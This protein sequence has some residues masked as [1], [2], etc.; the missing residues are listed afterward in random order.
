MQTTLNI[1]EEDRKT[2]VEAFG[3]ESGRWFKCPNGHVYVVT[4]C[5][6]ATEE[7]I[8]NECG[9]RVGGTNHYVG[10]GNNL[11]TEMD[12]AEAPMFPTA[13]DRPVQQ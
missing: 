7:S 10:D 6:G 13:L 12:G 11:A 3:Q 2:I 5:G 9:A 4:E 1:S 8:C